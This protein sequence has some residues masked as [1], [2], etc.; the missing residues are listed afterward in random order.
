MDGAVQPDGGGTL[1]RTIQNY[2]EK[3]W[4]TPITEQIEPEAVGKI[5]DQLFPQLPALMVTPGK[6][7]KDHHCQRQKKSMWR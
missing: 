2:D 5:M 3:G 1:W 6:M 7:R 4:G